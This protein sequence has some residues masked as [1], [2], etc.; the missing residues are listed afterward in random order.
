[1][2][3][4][5]RS[6][7]ALLLLVAP[8]ACS[9]SAPAPVASEEEVTAGR[10]RSP[11]VNGQ[12]TSD[13][14]QAGALLI[15][16]QAFCTGTLIGPRTVLTA[17]HCVK[18]QDASQMSFGIGASQYQLDTEIPVVAAEAHPQFDMQ[19]LV[20]DV[21]VVT[22]G[23]D[24]PLDPITLNPSMDD[25]WVGTSVKLVGYGVDD[26]AAQSN[27]G[28]KR[29][30]DVTIDQVDPTTLHYTTKQGKSACNGDSG[31]PA[32]ATVGGQLV[33]AGV[34]SYGDQTCQQFGVYTRVDAYLDFIE[35]FLNGAVPN[36]NPGQGGADPG[37]DPGAIPDPADPGQGADPG[38]W[39][40]P[41]GD[42]CGGIT[43]E[44]FC[45]GD[46]VVWC[47]SGQVFWE[48][49]DVCGYDPQFGYFSC[50]Q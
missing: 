9:A 11:I 6:L 19:Q 21:A 35:P 43:Y 40:D 24:A 50:V 20:N 22:L 34:T 42:P 27:A 1:M 18:G 30:V 5:L 15:Q 28:I 2:T 10:Q 16:G 7:A 31:G 33:V 38:G 47:E 46:V 32:F 36:P 45:D 4:T 26:G 3:T 17:G 14:P 12:A 37:V 25:S 44:G 23:Q 39:P 29:E 48:F 41:G 13:Y 49:C 8:V